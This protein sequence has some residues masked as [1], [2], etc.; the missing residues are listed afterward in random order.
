MKDLEQKI[1]WLLDRKKALAKEEVKLV[2]KLA[3]INTE[4]SAELI[5]KLYRR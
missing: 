3:L 2:K 1:N 5:N 4:Q